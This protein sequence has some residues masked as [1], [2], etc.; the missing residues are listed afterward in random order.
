MIKSRLISFIFILIF[1]NNLMYASNSKDEVVDKKIQNI[2]AEKLDDRSKLIKLF[3]NIIILEGKYDRYGKE[4]SGTPCWQKWIKLFTDEAYWHHFVK[5]PDKI[6]CD[7]CNV[8]FLEGWY[9]NKMDIEFIRILKEDGYMD[10]DGF[11]NRKKYKVTSKKVI[12]Y[13]KWLN[14]R[15]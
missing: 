15:M 2:I 4:F 9:K 11:F 10:S 3:E 12:K 14:S 1:C 8:M 5:N 13:M 7:N 6:G